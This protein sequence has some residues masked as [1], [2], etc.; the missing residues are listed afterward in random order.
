MS[1]GIELLLAWSPVLVAVIFG[2]VMT[3]VFVI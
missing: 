2:A 3:M 1:R